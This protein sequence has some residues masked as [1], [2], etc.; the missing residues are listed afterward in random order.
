M[1]IFYFMH[2]IIYP[3]SRTDLYSIHTQTHIIIITKYFGGREEQ[4]PKE[5]KKTHKTQSDFLN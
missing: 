2:P 4:N 5:K 3:L 1:S